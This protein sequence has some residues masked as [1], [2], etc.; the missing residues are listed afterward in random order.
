VVVLLAIVA[1]D[2]AVDRVDRVFLTGFVSRSRA[3]LVGC[4][5]CSGASKAEGLSTAAGVSGT[6]TT[7]AG[8]TAVVTAGSG[9]LLWLT[10]ST[11]IPDASTAPRTNMRT[12]CFI[13]SPLLFNVHE[14][15]RVAGTAIG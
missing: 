12:G 4:V 15:N 13:D 10:R 3:V 1:C 7:G 5:S 9:V 11:A 6:G 8:V 2:G 14:L